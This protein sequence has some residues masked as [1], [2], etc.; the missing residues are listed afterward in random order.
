LTQQTASGDFNK[1][2][3]DGS[4]VWLEY[5][6]DTMPAN[7]G[8]P[9]ILLANGR[10]VGIH[11]A[12]GC[13]D[14]GNKGTDFLH[15]PL[16]DGLNDFLGPNTEYVDWI[17]GRCFGLCTG[18]VDNPYGTVGE[19]V[20]EAQSGAIIAIVKGSY[21]AADGNRFTAGADG[22]AMTLVATVG[23]VTIGN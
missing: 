11:T 19:A 6:V 15:L 23:T 2:G 22:K 4:K 12:G 13:P 8:S 21:R 5:D 1:G 20:D 16:L 7:S 10:A 17:A 9:V 14:T 3:E 18:S